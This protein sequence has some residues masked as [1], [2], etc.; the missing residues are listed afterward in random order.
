[1]GIAAADA[2]NDG[3]IDFLLTHF[4]DDHNTY[5]QQYREGFWSDQSQVA[6][7]ADS[8]KPML[9]YG[10]QWID[11]DNDGWL[12]VFIANGDIDDFQLEGRSFRQPAQLLKQVTRGRWQL[13]QADQLGDYFAKGRLARAVATLDANRDGL[14]DLIV[15]HLF[16]PVALLINRSET[17]AKQTRFFLRARSTHRDAIG[18]R[19][20]FTRDDRTFEQQLLAGNGFQCVNEACIVFGMSDA[21][22]LEGVQVIWPD[23]TN[24]SLG[25]LVAGGDYLVIE[26]HGTRDVDANTFVPK[27]MCE[28]SRLL[29]AKATRPVERCEPIR[30][31]LNSRPMSAGSS[32]F[33]P[34]IQRPSRKRQNIARAVPP[35]G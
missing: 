14:S 26:G 19:V 15:T 35:S 4:V 32:L 31:K 13:M 3:D 9:A 7:F 21:E 1:M 20:R 11:V 18:A 6:G 22:K 2:D 24:E 28:L 29:M 10:T 12:E 8:S 5:Y 30:L 23:G 16:D 27:R 17:T 34:S 25:N 33:R